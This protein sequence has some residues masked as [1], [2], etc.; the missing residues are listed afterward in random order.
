MARVVQRRGGPPYLLVSFVILFLLA[1]AAA[2]LL[3]VQVDNLGNRNRQLEDNFR[4]AA[5]VQE[6]SNPTPSIRDMLNI[7]DKDPKRPTVLS[8]QAARIEDLGAIITGT[9]SGYSVAKTQAEQLAQD[10]GSTLG[11]GLVTET[12]DL[13]TELSKVR[14]ELEL[15][16]TQNLEMEEKLRQKDQSVAELT[17]SFTT[18]ID[19]LEAEKKELDD[20]VKQMHEGF[21]AEQQRLR[22]ELE[23]RRGELSMEIANKNQQLR[24]LEMAVEAKDQ[25]IER[26]RDELDKKR[27]TSGEEI[28]ARKADGKILQVKDR[29]DVCYINLGANDRI[30]PGLTFSVY[31]SAGIPENGEGKAKIAVTTVR[32]VVSECRIVER[33]GKEPIVPGD[34]VV[35]VAYDPRRTLTFVVDGQF[36]LRNRGQ[37]SPEDVQ[38]VKLLIQR[39]GGKVGDQVDVQTDFAVL[40]TEPPKPPQPSESAAEAVWAVYQAQLREY[41]RYQETLQAAKSMHV[42]ILNTNRFLALIGYSSKAPEK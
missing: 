29:Q 28:I 41:N 24:E 22:K 31:P 11:R 37:A 9:R 16:R 39:S 4:R 5:S 12:K 7:Y 2:V 13:Y 33:T 35:N 21:V 6:L 14:S 19:Q 18:K 34:L 40:G 17:H 38:E 42:P 10:I 30:T 32:D 27:G 36:D 1:A 20:K 3:W 25:T 23:D 26:L 15:L 8:Q